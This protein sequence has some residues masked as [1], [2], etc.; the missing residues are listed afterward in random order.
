MTTRSGTQAARRIVAGGVTQVVEAHALALARA[1]R[2]AGRAAD[3]SPRRSR[4]R[5]SRPTFRAA[6]NLD[7]Y[8]AGSRS[9]A[10]C[11]VVGRSALPG[12]TLRVIGLDPGARGAGIGRRLVEEIEREASR[13]GVRLISLGPDEAAGF[14]ERLGY[15]RSGDAYHKSIGERT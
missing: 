14:Y 13:L 5:R 6:C 3:F 8:T 9:T 15:A 11:D 4:A 2:D 1:V 10:G 7:L 12:V